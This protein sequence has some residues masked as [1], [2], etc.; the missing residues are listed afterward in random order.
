MSSEELLSTSLS[1]LSLLRD[2]E[3]ALLD[4]EPDELLSDEWEEDER[5]RL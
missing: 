1:L 4:E 5:D 2:F 3:L